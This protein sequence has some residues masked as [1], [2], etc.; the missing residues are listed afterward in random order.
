MRIKNTLLANGFSSLVNLI[1]NRQEWLDRPALIKVQDDVYA[2]DSSSGFAL[3]NMKRKA[4]TYV[5]SETKKTVTIDIQTKDDYYYL[6]QL[7]ESDLL[8]GSDEFEDVKSELF[9]IE[10]ALKELNDKK[11]RLDAT[12]HHIESSIEAASIYGFV[13]ETICVEFKKQ[14]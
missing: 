4:I 2:L 5:C 6:Q 8:F 12:L 1:R 9:D 10:N 14:N 3:I 7:I 11:A 13:P